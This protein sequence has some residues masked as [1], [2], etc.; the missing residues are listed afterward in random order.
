VI[1]D[2]THCGGAACK[3]VSVNPHLSASM[4]LRNES[5]LGTSDIVGPTQENILVMQV[6][7]AAH[8]IEETLRPEQWLYTCDLPY[9]SYPLLRAI[10]VNAHE[11]LTALR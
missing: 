4:S 6:L 7:H 11:T 2:Q 3:A 9:Y 8:D 5:F 1:G 10:H